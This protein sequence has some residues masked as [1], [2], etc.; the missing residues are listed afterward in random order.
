[1]TSATPSPMASQPSRAEQGRRGSYPLASLVAR[2]MLALFIVLMLMG[3]VPW[4][5]TRG[6]GAAVQVVIASLPSVLIHAAFVVLL[7]KGNTIVA[8]VFGLWCGWGLM[9]SFSGA[10]NTYV[11][12]AGYAF[13]VLNFIGIA[14]VIKGLKAKAA[15]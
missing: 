13:G 1:M 8:V 4:F 3:A 11:A 9:S 12:I 15:P 10:E 2:I 5:F 7:P 14:G 6:P